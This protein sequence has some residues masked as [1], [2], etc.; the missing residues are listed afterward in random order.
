MRLLP[1]AVVL[2]AVC[3]VA[4][5]TTVSAPSPALPAPPVPASS[6]RAPDLVELTPPPAR[7]LLAAVE[8]EAEAPA[9]A[10][11]PSPGASAGA[12]RAPRRRHAPAVRHRAKPPRTRAPRLPASGGPCML[13]RTYGGWV[14]GSPAATICARAYGN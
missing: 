3:A 10:A 11:A 4:G 14:A 8:P 5:C 2:A 7:P 12:P 13:G 1:A 6:R 9:V